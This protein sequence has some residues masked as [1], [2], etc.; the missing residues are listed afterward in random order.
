[1]IDTLTCLRRQIAFDRMI[2]WTDKLRDW[3][4]A[5]LLQHLL[6][7]LCRRS[8]PADGLPGSA[9]LIVRTLAAIAQIAA[10]VGVSIGRTAMPA[11]TTTTMG[12]GRQDVREEQDNGKDTTQSPPFHAEIS[13]T[14][15]L[16]VVH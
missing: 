4:H 2:G 8:V 6:L 5:T 14:R 9:K 10:S 1:M 3:G 13:C 11:M 12:N 7:C 15:R 16:R